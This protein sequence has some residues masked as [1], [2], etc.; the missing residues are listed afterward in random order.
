MASELVTADGMPEL[1][2]AT[3]MR[4]LVHKVAETVAFLARKD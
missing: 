1:V 3:P 4:R 2:A